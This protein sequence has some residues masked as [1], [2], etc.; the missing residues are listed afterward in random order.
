MKILLRDARTGQYLCG[1]NR[2]TDNPAEGYDWQHSKRLL[3]Y[4]KERGLEGMD[5]AVKYLGCDAV[6]VYPLQVAMPVGV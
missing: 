1:A 2:W 6:E 4:V 5:I 3:D